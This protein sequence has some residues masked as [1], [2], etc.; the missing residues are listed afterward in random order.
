MPNPTKNAR[1]YGWKWEKKPVT[2]IN[3][4]VISQSLNLF[5]SFHINIVLFQFI[6]S[7][8][9]SMFHIYVVGVLCGVPIASK[10]NGVGCNRLWM[11]QCVLYI[12]LSCVR[13][14]NVAP[15]TTISIGIITRKCKIEQT[16]NIIIV[17]ISLQLKSSVFQFPIWWMHGIYI[18]RKWCNPKHTW[19][20]P[21]SNFVAR[22]W[23]QDHSYEMRNLFESTQPIHTIYTAI[24][25]RYTKHHLI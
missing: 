19:N 2:N 9:L 3:S 11:S 5:F 23:Q 1:E 21:F 17:T 6:F 10:T 24:H 20:W 16:K 7:L 12:L 13:L 15:N 22:F 4:V 18:Y 25:T 14:N 8:A